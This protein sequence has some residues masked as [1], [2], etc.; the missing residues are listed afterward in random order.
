MRFGSYTPAAAGAVTRGLRTS[1]R[2]RLIRTARTRLRRARRERASGMTGL[3]WASV[4]RCPLSYGVRVRVLPSLER[5]WPPNWDALVAGE[6]CEVCAFVLPESPSAV[7]DS[8]P[9]LPPP[10]SIQ[11][12]S[13]RPHMSSQLTHKA[14]EKQRMCR[15]SGVKDQAEICGRLSLRYRRRRGCRS[16]AAL[17]LRGCR[18][19]SGR[20]QR[21]RSRW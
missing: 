8:P 17:L 11:W 12:P 19:G 2:I 3:A 1:A 9:P 6:G 4:P 10:A 14:L 21:A 18:P 5:A 13:P 15:V 16:K 20:H 7:Q